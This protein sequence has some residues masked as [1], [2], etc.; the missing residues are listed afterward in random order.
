MCESCIWKHK[1]L[2]DKGM[3][4][5]MELL[6]TT[7]DYSSI[8]EGQRFCGLSADVCD[9]SMET[10]ALLDAHCQVIQPAH[11]IPWRQE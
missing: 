3:E 7:G 9:H 1:Q 11:V 6:H 5:V 4:N 8:G 2:K 10:Q